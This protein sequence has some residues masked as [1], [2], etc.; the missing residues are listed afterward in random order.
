MLTIPHL[1]HL[2]NR[3]LF[4]Y[5]LLLLLLSLML[6][7]RMGGKKIPFGKHSFCARHPGEG[8]T[9]FVSSHP[10]DLP[11]RLCLASSQFSDEKTE[12]QSTRDL[13][14]V[15]QPRRGG[16]SMGPRLPHPK[17]Q[18]LTHRGSGLP[19]HLPPASS[20]VGLNKAAC[21]IHALREKNENI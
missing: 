7:S 8:S 11:L 4:C 14:K 5:F 2:D 3:L 9:H 18:V 19:V 13:S 10:Y 21:V 6:N 17:P 20:H 15:P 1:T 12:A 16:M